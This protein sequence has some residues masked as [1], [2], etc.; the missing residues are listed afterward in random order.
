VCTINKY[1][2]R[3]QSRTFQPAAPIRADAMLQRWA[4]GMRRENLKIDVAGA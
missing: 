3:T 1:E 2:F 4:D